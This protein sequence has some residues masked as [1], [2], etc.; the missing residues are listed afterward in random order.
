MQQSQKNFLDKYAKKLFRIGFKKG[1]SSI[2]T[3]KM[4]VWTPTGITNI[5]KCYL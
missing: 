5:W 1:F 4:Q 2:A 3:M